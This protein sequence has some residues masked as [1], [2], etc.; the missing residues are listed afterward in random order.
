MTSFDNW[1]LHAIKTSTPTL[2][3]WLTEHLRFESLLQP[4]SNVIY[5]IEVRWH[6]KPLLSR[7]QCVPWTN[8]PQYLVRD[9]IHNM[10]ADNECTLDINCCMRSA[11]TTRYTVIFTYSVI[12]IKYEKDT[13][14]ISLHP[15]LQFWPLNIQKYES[16]ISCRLRNIFDLTSD[17]NSG[18]R[19]FRTR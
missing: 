12:S 15:E 16:I 3:D 6:S 18:N 19:D 11:T 4:I 10:Q 9:T 17:Y 13:F 7:R 14:P 2:I 8:L 5:L 1:F